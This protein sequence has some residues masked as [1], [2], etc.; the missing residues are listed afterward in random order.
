MFQLSSIQNRTKSQEKE[1]MVLE[2]KLSAEE[3]ESG[4]QRP[5]QTDARYVASVTP[6]FDAEL[7]RLFTSIKS[8]AE[9][10]FRMFAILKKQSKCLY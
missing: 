9:T 2:E 1:K 3:A 7:G 4:T 8:L 10:R 6:Y 5:L